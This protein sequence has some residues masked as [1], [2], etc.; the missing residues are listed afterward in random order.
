[1]VAIDLGRVTGRPRLLSSH[2]EVVAHLEN[3][4]TARCPWPWPP[5]GWRT[6]LRSIVSASSRDDRAAS[7]S[8][9]TNGICELKFRLKQTNDRR[10]LHRGWLI[11]ALGLMMAWMDRV[12]S[13]AGLAAEFACAIKLML[14][15]PA[16]L[17]PH[18]DALYEPAGML[19]E[20]S[21]EFPLVSVGA[22]EQFSAILQ[23]FDEDLWDLAGAKVQ[24]MPTFSFALAP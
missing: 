19:P 4:Q 13:E 12:R 22:A 1:M 3:D 6:Q 23:R 5:E 2:A 20:G 14:G 21:H 11:G 9:Q 15:A 16:P 18:G 7:Y 8:L 24:G 10:V 17:S